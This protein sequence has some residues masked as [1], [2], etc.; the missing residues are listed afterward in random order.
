MAGWQPELRDHRNED[1]EACTQLRNYT[2]ARRV[3]RSNMV[4]FQNF[5][6]FQLEHIMW[7]FLL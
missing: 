7:V 3:D 1:C 5:Q 2:H 4:N 6:N